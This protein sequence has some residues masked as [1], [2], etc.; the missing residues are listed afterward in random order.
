MPATSKGYTA[1]GTE[2]CSRSLTPSE[3]DA[4]ALFLEKTD[5]FLAAVIAALIVCVGTIVTAA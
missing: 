4:I 3:E 5:H 1:D 2:S